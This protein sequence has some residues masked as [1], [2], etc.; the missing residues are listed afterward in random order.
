MNA[1]H[2][3]LKYA[4]KED[5]LFLFKT[6]KVGNLNEWEALSGSAMF[7]ENGNVVGMTI[8][9]DEENGIVRV[10]P[11]KIILRLIDYSLKYESDK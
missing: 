8:R 11:M 6:S 2:C 5:E 4:G 9:Y 7:D 3:E 1:L 10:M